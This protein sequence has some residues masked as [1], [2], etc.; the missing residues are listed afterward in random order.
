MELIINGRPASIKQGSSFDLLLENRSFTEADAFTMSITLPLAGCP[1]NLAIFGH[2]N[3]KDV[4]LGH[5]RLPASLVAGGFTRDG[6]VAM[7]EMS[8]LEIKCQFLEGRSVQNYDTTF[9]TIFINELDLGSFDSSLTDAPADR[10]KSVD[11]ADYVAIP[12]VN[13]A[14]GNIQN[15]VV[16]N[17]STWAWDTS[18]CSG[19][20][21]QLYLIRLAERVFEALEYDVDFSAWEASPYVNLVC[22][23]A[24]PYAWDRSDFAGAMPH[25][26]VS[27]FVSELESFLNAFIDIDHVRR[28]ARLTFRAALA[29]TSSQFIVRDPADS[30]TVE[31]TDTDESGYLDTAN[32][33]YAANDYDRVWKFWSCDWLV[34]ALPK[35]VAS[36]DTLEQLRAI[37]EQWETSSGGEHRNSALSKIWWCKEANAH[38]I[39]RGVETWPHLIVGGQERYTTRYVLEPINIFGN[40]LGPIEDDQATVELRIIPVAIDH[41]DNANG[42]CV[43]VE[44]PGS[45]DE[46]GDAADIDNTAASSAPYQ[47]I[48]ERNL[49]AGQREDKAY[50]DTLMV[51]FWHGPKLQ[52]LKNLPQPPVVSHIART[53][54]MTFSL[55]SETLSLRR[56]GPAASEYQTTAWDIDPFHKYTIRFISDEVPD[57]TALFIIDNKRYLCLRLTV[58][59]TE[60]DKSSVIKGEFYQV[61]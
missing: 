2:I 15:K 55:D 33:Y 3:R 44:A 11:Q 43:F 37:G 18:E 19:L 29:R 28:T 1:E 56:E 26:T 4:A 20:S 25:W 31:Q 58:S 60:F 52:G 9:D 8:D 35:Y 41:T 51:G 53:G 5:V 7:V 30:F 12:W 61:L 46:D 10:M 38:F 49:R 34:D 22:F 13:N 45:Y 54:A 23:N 48:P 59:F 42:F 57:P 16:R 21:C 39:F 17:G 32:Y 36:V 40:S 50:Y 14:S 47:Q 24:L 27:Q 6:I